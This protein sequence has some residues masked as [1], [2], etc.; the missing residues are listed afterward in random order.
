MICF[1]PVHKQN[2]SE[3]EHRSSLGKKM[4]IFPIVYVFVI[5]RMQLSLSVSHVG[6]AKLIACIGI[7]PYL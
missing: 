4:K 7:I 2:L 5:I 1:V 3:F 6:K